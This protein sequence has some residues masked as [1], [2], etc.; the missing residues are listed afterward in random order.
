M[1]TVSVQASAF[2]A[3]KLMGN[4]GLLRQLLFNECHTHTYQQS[5]CRMAQL[6]DMLAMTTLSKTLILSNADVQVAA[7]PA[8]A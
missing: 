1:G 2:R 3:S 5:G 6:K 4:I 8:N 7:S